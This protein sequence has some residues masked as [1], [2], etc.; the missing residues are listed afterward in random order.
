MKVFIDDIYYGVLQIGPKPIEA[1]DRDYGFE[2]YQNNT[3]VIS[4]NRSSITLRPE[5]V[6]NLLS[7][8]KHG[9]L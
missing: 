2:N 7:L 9:D 6:K 3:I 5:H 1:F 4:D 8:K